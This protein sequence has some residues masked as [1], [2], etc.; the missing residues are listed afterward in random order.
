MSYFLNDLVEQYYFF[1]Y[2]LEEKETEMFLENAISKAE[3]EFQQDNT[4]LDSVEFKTEDNLEYY[5]K[6][7]WNQLIEDWNLW[8]SGDKKS[9]DVY[10]LAHYQ[11]MKNE[12][13]SRVKRNK[14]LSFITPLLAL[15]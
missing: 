2:K 14:W 11:V 12:I 13:K 4:D 7:S 3:R 6:L 1:Q 10:Y 15:I 8:S 5:S 9:S